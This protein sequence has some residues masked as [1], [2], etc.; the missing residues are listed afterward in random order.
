MN[1][2]EHNYLKN[3]LPANWREGYTSEGETFNKQE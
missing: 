1:Y 3:A 2:I